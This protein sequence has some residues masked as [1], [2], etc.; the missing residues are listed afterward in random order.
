MLSTSGSDLENATFVSQLNEMISSR[1]K[2]TNV[3]YQVI[4]AGKAPRKLLKHFVL[5]RYPI[6]NFWTRNILG[7]AARLDDY[8]LRSEL[9]ENIY[10]EETGALTKTRRHLETFVDFGV[11]L[12]LSR[13]DIVAC[14]DLLPETE[15]VIEHNVGTCNRSDIDFT[16]GVA[17]VLLLMEG[18]PPIVNRDGLSMESVMRDV[19]RLPPKGY[20]YFSVHASAT[21]GQKVSEIEE[22]HASTAREILTRYCTSDELRSKAIA[23]LERAINLRHAHFSAIYERFYDPTEPPFR[24]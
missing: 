17:S 15:A 14:R 21:E 5:Q 2:M 4:L 22:D 11:C 10:E 7:I 23:A 18:Q 19:Y 1:K 9:I 3:L 13:A 20:E 16:Q 24:V 6:K 8:R 12:G